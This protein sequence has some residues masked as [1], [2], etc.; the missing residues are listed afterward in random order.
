[1]RSEPINVRSHNRG[2]WD[3]LAENRDRWTQ[4]V[5]SE[6]IDAAR[7]GNIDIVLTPTRPVPRHWFP[8]LS[9]LATLCLASGG[10]Q[11][12]PLLAAAGACVTVL[13]NSPNQLARDE[14]VAQREGLNLTTIEGDMADLSC[15]DDETFELIV[16][17]CSNV[18]VPDTNPVWRECYRV[19]RPGGVLL[20]GFCNPVRFLFDDER[21]ENGKLDVRYSIPYS[22]LDHLDE[23]H[24][25]VVVDEGR[26]L[27][28]G[29][30]LD[31]LIGGQLQ[32]GF[33]LTGFYEDRYEEPV[34]DPLSNYMSSFIATRAVK[35]MNTGVHNVSS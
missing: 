5:S 35:L 21:K 17:P 25:R 4:P 14:F 12:S 6:A 16:H 20:S 26:P 8:S 3:Q 13:D 7:R 23:P 18:F 10:G 34:E 33:I 31:D 9:G 27:E 30:S 15:F 11:Q 2:A 29:H 28:F 19:L 24:L 22:D 1:M 32:A